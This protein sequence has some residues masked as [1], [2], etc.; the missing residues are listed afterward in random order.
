LEP[1]YYG[2]EQL[3]YENYYSPVT[4]AEFKN[5]WHFTSVPP[6]PF[7]TWYFY[8]GV[9]LTF[10]SIVGIAT[11]Y[12]LDDGGVGVRVPVGSR[13]FSSL[14]RPDWLWGPPSLLFNGYWGLFLRG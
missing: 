1:L 10:Y 7:M 5:I 11:G 8:I 12:R 4:S 2:I 3:E 9:F 14:H 13:I 6:V